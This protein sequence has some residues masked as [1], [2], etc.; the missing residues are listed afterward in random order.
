ML[1]N[2]RNN[3]KDG[4][5]CGFKGW[6]T[7]GS[8]SWSR[9]CFL[10]SKVLLFSNV[11]WANMAASPPNPCATILQQ[12]LRP[13]VGFFFFIGN[14]LRRPSSVFNPH[15]LYGKLSFFWTYLLLFLGSCYLL[16]RVITRQDVCLVFFSFG[17]GPTGVPWGTP[18][19]TLKHHCVVPALFP[20]CTAVTYLGHIGYS[21]T[22]YVCTVCDR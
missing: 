15:L 13:R 4:D 5:C 18:L 17:G 9:S 22:P 7:F 2:K 6:E 12:P 11:C 21:A 20:G 16:R 8:D 14:I 19:S 3:E 10:T 1:T